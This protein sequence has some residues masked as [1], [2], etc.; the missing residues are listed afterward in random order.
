MVIRP[1]RIRNDAQAGEGH[2]TFVR[3]VST[4]KNRCQC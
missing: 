4:G 1:V 2:D 3:L